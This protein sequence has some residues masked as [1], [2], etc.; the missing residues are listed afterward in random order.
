MIKRSTSA[1]TALLLVASVVVGSPPAYSIFASNTSGKVISGANYDL[2]NAPWQ[3][4]L[5]SKK[6][7]NFQGQFC[8]G[9][10]ISPSHVLTAAHCVDDLRNAREIVIANTDYLNDSK[11]NR[12]TIKRVLIHPDWDP[13]SFENDIAILYLKKPIKPVFGDSRSFIAVTNSHAATL[14]AAITGW[15]NTSKIGFIWPRSLQGAEI[16]ISN[17]IDADCLNNVDGFEVRSMIC[18]GVA[19]YRVV[20]TCQGDSG[21]PMS[22]RIGGKNTLIGI[23]SWGI[24]CADGFPGVYARVASYFDWIDRNMGPPPSNLKVV[25][26]KKLN[27][28][29]KAAR[30]TGKNLDGVTALLV[31]G[32][33]VEITKRSARS[34]TFILNEKY[35]GEP[36]HVIEASRTT[37]VN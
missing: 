24:R 7:G 19:P 34:L 16:S 13:V 25:V 35:T 8:G 1:V 21:G 33:E 10:L 3:V 30:V 14:S 26:K 17:P 4:A 20:D 32:E 28:A 9:S 31:N 22:A 5:I 12:H 27:R 18:G 2:E 36:V 29:G 15:G 23:T 37:E 11:K 6:Q